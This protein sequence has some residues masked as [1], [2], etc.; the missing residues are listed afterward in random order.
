MS[1]S[2]IENGPGHT[3]EITDGP[4]EK[5]KATAYEYAQQRCFTYLPS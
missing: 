4:D 5:D 3:P 2:D 1:S